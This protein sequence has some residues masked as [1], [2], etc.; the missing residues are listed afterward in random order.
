M[1]RTLF[2]LLV[3]MT[4]VNTYCNECKTKHEDICIEVNNS[5]SSLL[6]QHQQELTRLDYASRPPCRQATQLE[7]TPLDLAP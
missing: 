5:R 7:L 2:S 4:L 3:A 6:C 1:L